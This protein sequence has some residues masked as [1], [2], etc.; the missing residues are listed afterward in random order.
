VD[1]F[2]EFGLN[3]SVVPN[4]VPCDE[5]RYRRREAQGTTLL[6]TRHF[7]P[8]Y[9]VDLV[10]RAFGRIKEEFSS[11]RLCL[12]GK[13]SQER[14]IR[15]LVRQLNLEDVEFAGPVA[16]RE[17]SHLYDRADIFMNASWLDNMPVSILE[18]YAS[19]TPVVSTAPEGIQHI[20]KH[21]HTGLL[22]Q[23]GDWHQLAENA[24]R[25]FRDPQLAARLAL[26][27]YKQSQHYRWAA[28][29]KQWLQIYRS[30]HQIHGQENGKQFVCSSSR[31]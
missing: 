24:I 3:A 16:H 2:Q 13:G 10:V 14:E 1:V 23:P 30:L 6:C 27:A 21:E 20:V 17:I 25:L 11:A 12:V 18:A 4:I 22:C 15:A 31:S 5:F 8:Y 19:G 7:E 26:E 28:V 29:G 9:G